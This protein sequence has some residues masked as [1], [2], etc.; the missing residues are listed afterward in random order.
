MMLVGIMCL[1]LTIM[2]LIKAAIAGGFKFNMTKLLSQTYTR[3]PSIFFNIYFFTKM[4]Y[5]LFSV[6]MGFYLLVAFLV[7][8]SIEHITLPE[9]ARAFSE[10]RREL[11]SK[12]S[13]ARTL[14]INALI[15]L[16]ITLHMTQNIYWLK[17]MSSS[18]IDLT[19]TFKRSTDEG[20]SEDEESQDDEQGEDSEG[21]G[22]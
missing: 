10:G 13:V 22:M 16:V 6:L 9:G 15:V 1:V 3:G 17:L 21:G 18:W 12:A 5:V 14:G 20:E 8:Y 7:R 4:L 19:S 2:S 11:S